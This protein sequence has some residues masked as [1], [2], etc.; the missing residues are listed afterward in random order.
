MTLVALRSGVLQRSCEGNTHTSTRTRSTC[1]ITITRSPLL[2]FTHVRL[3]HMRIGRC[4]T[5]VS[6][7]PL[8]ARNAGTLRASTTSRGH[9][10]QLSFSLGRSTRHASSGSVSRRVGLAPGPTNHITCAI[11]DTQRLLAPTRTDA[12]ARAHTHTHTFAC[13]CFTL[14]DLV[15]RAVTSRTRMLTE[16][17]RTLVLQDVETGAVMEHMRHHQHFVQGV[18]WHPQNK[19]IATQSCD[20]RCPIT[21]P[22]H[23]SPRPTVHPPSQ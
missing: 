9:Q 13:V 12:R 23:V 11:P 5:S 21:L 15:H 4:H 22:A 17:T 16:C 10:T 7:L 1:T 2:L 6:S 20:R 14:R 18:A 3:P 8:H 19:C